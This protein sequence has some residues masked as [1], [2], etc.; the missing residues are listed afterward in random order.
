MPAA[1][2]RTLL[3]AL[4]ALL[5]LAGPASASRSMDT[6]FEA[7]QDLINVEPAERSAALDDIQSLGVK[8]LRVVLL[9]QKVAPEPDA[10]RRPDFNTTDPDSYAW[11]GYDALLTEA[12]QR[13]LEVLL[14]VSG[15][16]PTWATEDKKKGDHTTRPN[17]GDFAQFTTA[18]GRKFKDRV[19]TWSIW[20]EPNQPQFLTPQY[21][22][23]K[24][25]V[26]G[27]FYRA[28]YKAALKG[29]RSAKVDDP[30][31]LFGETSPRGTGKVVAPLTF[32]RQAL[33]VDT[34]GRLRKGCGKLPI[35]GIA[36]HAYTTRAGPRFRPSGPNDVTIGVL[37][38]L[39]SLMKR[40]GDSKAIAKGLP[41]YLTEFGIQSTPDPVFGVVQQ[42]QDEYR[43]LS[44]RIAYYNPRVKAFSQYLLRDDRPNEDAKSK[45]SRYPGFESGLRTSGGKDKQAYDSFRL[46]LSA[47]R[48]SSRITTLWGLVR[49]AGKATTAVVEYRS[50]RRGS[51]R[52]LKTVRTNS[53]GFYNV[54]TRT[55]KD[56]QYR[57]SWESPSGETLT[58]GPI[59]ALK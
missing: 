49:P 29:L 3:L 5:V 17:R 4:L 43:N 21:D 48:K 18:V 14:T 37:N 9:W 23:K 58:G 52:K 40:A 25:P 10:T 51:W 41:L 59:R 55:S 15:P 6:S 42:R 8:S 7:P 2:L 27:R 31:V 56:R 57:L 19:D 22:S 12:K 34:K 45:F 11:G 50:G 26:S 36:H 44:E 46:V 54:R 53:R 28:L 32:L 20:N 16:V 35:D 24:R 33:C 39:T 47:L 1:S 30:T 13:G 38:R